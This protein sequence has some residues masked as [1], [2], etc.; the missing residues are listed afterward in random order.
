[1]A[2][3]RTELFFSSGLQFMQEA[4]VALVIAGVG[5]IVALVRTWQE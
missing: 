5:F 4:N 1:M 3:K 2:D